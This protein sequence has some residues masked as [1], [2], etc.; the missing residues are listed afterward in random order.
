MVSCKIID[1]CSSYVRTT[2][3]SFPEDLKTRDYIEKCK[4]RPFCEKNDIKLSPLQ[5]Q[6]IQNMF[7]T[8]Q[9]KTYILLMLPSLKTKIKMA[10]AKEW[11]DGETFQFRNYLLWN[12]LGGNYFL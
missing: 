3:E 12:R 6:K 2:V 1:F 11:T 4:Q 7:T 9:C 8:L 5:R 10:A